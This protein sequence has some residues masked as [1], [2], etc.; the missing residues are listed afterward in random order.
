MHGFGVGRAVSMLLQVSHHLVEIVDEVEIALV[1]EFGKLVV[2]AH[3]HPKGIDQSVQVL[4]LLQRQ[5]FETVKI[6]FEQ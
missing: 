3:I 2:A 6:R 4:V 1:L 5:I